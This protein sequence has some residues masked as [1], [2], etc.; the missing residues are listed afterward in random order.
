MNEQTVLHVVDAT[1]DVGYCTAAFV[2]QLARRTGARTILIGTARDERE[3]RSAGLERIA[4]FS[5]PLGTLVL[6]TRA[7][8]AI[9]R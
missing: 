7:W 5:P 8:R 3:A 9:L 1:R 6:A 2:A 4:V